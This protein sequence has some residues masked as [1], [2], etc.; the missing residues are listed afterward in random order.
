MGRVL[1][2]RYDHTTV[3]RVPKNLP[4]L[5][6][7]DNEGAEEYT[8]YSWWIKWNTLYY[9]DE[10]KEIQEINL[11]SENVC[12]KRPTDIEEEEEDFDSDDEEKEEEEDEEEED[13][14][15]KCVCCNETVSNDE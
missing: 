8:P 2:A 6:Q 9:Y 14:K 5:S 7:D 12:T 1:I 11:Y 4:L 3:F 13:E 10:K 15:V